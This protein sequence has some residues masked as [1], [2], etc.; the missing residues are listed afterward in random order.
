[1]CRLSPT[2]DLSPTRLLLEAGLRDNRW[3]GYSLAGYTS[4]Q[5]FSL[6]GGSVSSSSSSVPWYSA[7]KPVTAI[8]VLQILARDP[9]L[10]SLAMEKTFPELR[11]SYAGTL[12]LETILT[13]RTG[14]RFPNLPIDGSEK[15]IFGI[16]SGSRP[17]DFSL[18]P[19]QAAYDPRGGWWL[20]GQWISRQTDQPWADFLHQHV[21]QPAG[22]SAMFF[23]NAD[24][25]PDV[26]MT[27]KRGDQWLPSPPSHGPGG[28]LCG[29][30]ADLALLYQTL[31]CDGISPVTGKTVLDSPSLET[32]TRRWREGEV[33]M[34]FGHI[35]DFGLGIILD[36]NRY[37][38]STVP[39]GFGTASSDQS[40]GHGGARSS[41][42]FADPENHLALAVCLIGL[43]PENVHQPR[44]R[45]LLDQLRSDLA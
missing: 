22:A 13:H 17:Q 29:P 41:I 16:L 26:P 28:G 3:A 27:E 33:D 45:V 43:V 25:H 19:G 39:Y 1:M 12:T 23:A 20:L 30:A 15:E 2:P 11:K 7:G 24:H 40:Y 14:L 18:R 8:G 5:F 10:F 44:M 32:M 4:G 37:G 36:G 34:T 21:L 6:H 9:G 42:A 38:S 35:V 31:L